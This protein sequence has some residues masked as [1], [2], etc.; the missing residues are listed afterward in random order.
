MSESNF[1]SSSPV[2]SSDAVAQC[3]V[4]SAPV[5]E[6]T[7]SIK[8]IVDAIRETF[9]PFIPLLKGEWRRKKLT[10]LTTY[11]VFIAMVAMILQIVDELETK[12][13]ALHTT[14][15][16]GMLSEFEIESGES[17]GESF[18]ILTLISNVLTV[19]GEFADQDFMGC[20][21]NSTYTYPKKFD[22]KWYLT[23]RECE[24]TFD[25]S[26][27]IKF[28]TLFKL[29]RTNVGRF[30]QIANAGRSVADTYAIPSL[31]QV[32]ELAYKVR[33]GDKTHTGKQSKAW[34]AFM[35]E[36]IPIAHQFESFE[37][38]LSDIYSIFTAAI[39]ACKEEKAEKERLRAERLL[40]NANAPAGFEVVGVRRTR[41]NPNGVPSH[42]D[43]KVVQ[44]S[45][46]PA[47]KPKPTSTAAPVVSLVA[48]LPP[49]SNAW[50]GQFNPV[51]GSTISQVAPAA[52]V[53]ISLTAPV[54]DVLHKTCNQRHAE[55]KAIYCKEMTPRQQKQHE[56]C[57]K[58]EQEQKQKTTQKA[59][60]K[61]CQ[62]PRQQVVAV[63]VPQNPFAALV[64]DSD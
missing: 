57:N 40:R 13:F 29:A 32:G 30:I 50:G 45:V 4:P 7:A 9:A 43:A 18:S 16:T 24:Q 55:R 58:W 60:P 47:S 44:K 1:L 19:F 10:E 22:I 14:I 36:W 3:D 49:P 54:A 34:I 28:V 59:T 48:P 53:V 39:K 38:D 5:E 56:R 23:E 25:G 46:K 41:T 35:T 63:I 33:V 26:D 20:T 51:T 15:V 62:A 8:A 11:E 27:K 12:K 52:H 6:E 2:A 64:V 17:S 31:D 42:A 61:Q 21:A 37:E